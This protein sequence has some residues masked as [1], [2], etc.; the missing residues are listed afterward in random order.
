MSKTAKWIFPLAIVLAGACSG[1]TTR[2]GDPVASAPPAA[3]APA[4]SGDPASPLAPPSRPEDPAV[5]GSLTRLDSLLTIPENAYDIFGK[6]RKHLRAFS[7]SLRGKL[8]TPEQTGSILAY[9]DGLLTRHPEAWKLIGEQRYLAENLTP[10]KIAP[11]IVGKDIDGVEFELEDHRGD[12]VVLFFTGE[13]CAP[14]RAAYPYQRRMLERYK[15]ENVVLLGVNSDRK[16]ETVQEAK[17]REGLHY[18]TWWDESTRGPIATSWIV[19]AWPTTYIL[20]GKGVIR[21]VNTREEQLIEAVDALLREQR[22]V[23]PAQPTM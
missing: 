22:A 6:G 18:R 2:D 13:W 10:G 3:P 15:D 20:D 9:M 4:S 11:N 21:H 19:W 23:D 7:D 1:M 8:L 16:I 12:I 5:D 14:C 17:E